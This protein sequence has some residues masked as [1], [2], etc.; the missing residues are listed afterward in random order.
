M[1]VSYRFSSVADTTPADES[2]VQDRADEVTFTLVEGGTKRGKK[3]LVSSD[4]YSYT[5]KVRYLPNIY[6][7]LNNNASVCLLH[8][9]VVNSVL[10]LYLQREGK[11]VTSWWCSVRSKTLHCHAT[12]QQHGDGF[13]RGPQQHLHPCQPGLGIKKQITAKVSPLCPYYCYFYYCPCLCCLVFSG[14]LYTM[15]PI[16]LQVRADAKQKTHVFTASSAIVDA[17]M[18]AEV[19]SAPEP[20]RPNPINLVRV[21][22]RA[23][24]GMRPPEPRD[25]KFDVSCLFFVF[26]STSLSGLHVL[27]SFA[28]PHWC[29]V[30]LQ[31]ATAF[32]PDDFLQADISGDHR[33]HLVF[34]T[35]QQLKILSQAKTWYLDGTFKVVGEPFVQLFSVHAFLKH[36]GETKQVPLAFAVMSGRKKR[37]YKKVNN[38]IRVNRIKFVVM[39]LEYSRV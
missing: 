12:V 39:I 16:I 36:D 33:R 23:R 31:L 25:L 34:A 26:V 4:G 19:G 29:V 27:F 14:R 2:L 7:Y 18:T 35:K 17:A 15:C 20:G 28:I 5:V 10:L 21:A 24:Q 13:T 1:N 6:P 32:L 37:D 8:R 11:T 30:S 9:Y 22:N 38:G 3:L